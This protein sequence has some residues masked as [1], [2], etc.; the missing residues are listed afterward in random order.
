MYLS[1]LVIKIIQLKS[2]ILVRNKFIMQKNKYT[3][4][5]SAFVFLL[6]LCC[7]YQVKATHLMGGN[8]TYSYLGVNATGQK[9]YAVNAT[10]FRDCK[11]INMPSSAFIT[12]SS[13]TCGTVNAT[14][15]NF[16]GGLTVTPLCANEQDI[17]DPNIPN[18]AAAYGVQSWLY[19]GTVTLPNCGNDWRIY[20]SSCCRNNAI[21]TLTSAGSFYVEAQLDNIVTGGNSSPAFNN[22][23][24]LFLCANQENSYNNGL[25]DTENDSLVY[26]LVNCL[27]SANGSVSYVSGLSGSNPLN[28]L[29][30]NIDAETGDVQVFPTSVQVGV[31]CMLVEEYRNGVKIGQVVR[32]LQ[33]TVTDCAFNT[34]PKLSGLN[35][36]ADSTSVTGNY[37]ATIC[38]NQQTCFDI[39]GFDAEAVPSAQFQNLEMKWNYGING[40][41]FVVDYN[42]PYPVGQFCWTPDDNDIGLQ[43]FFVIAKD[44]ACP[45]FGTNVY[46]YKLD[47]IPEVT[48]E[49]TQGDVTINPGDSVTLTTTATSSTS[50]YS[51]TP[52]TGLSCTDCP[53]PIATPPGGTTITYT[54]TA[55]S[56]DGCSASD[57]VT[58]TTYAVSTQKLP[59]QVADWTVFPNPI[60]TQ[61]VVEYELISSANINLELYSVTGQHVATLE[62]TQ[63]D[64]GTYQYRLNRYLDGKAKG[65]YLLRLNVDGKSVTQKIIY[66]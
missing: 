7:S 41:S 40:A 16:G 10:L 66:R 44:D 5:L 43:T 62:N 27:E 12:L 18:S 26:S 54:V 3:I 45:I 24:T 61:S 34:L 31:V 63:Q 14:L 39:Q 53:N 15:Q 17:C 1:Q 58:I 28:A 59:A 50:S 46:T 25:T 52:T 64:A 20:W 23:P 60:T 30:T 8:I 35:G 2:L 33:F 49:I 11:G 48:V 9:Q 6:T 36:T 55:S 56:D 32:D 21:T 65:I 4:I 47:V 38:A 51:W 22:D 42:L 57:D 37:E 29:Y 19:R 13:P